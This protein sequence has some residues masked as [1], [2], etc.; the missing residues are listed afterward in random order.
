LNGDGK[1]HIMSACRST[2]GVV[3]ISF[4]LSRDMLWD[5]NYA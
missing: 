1:A 3:S 5:V 4:D 2:N